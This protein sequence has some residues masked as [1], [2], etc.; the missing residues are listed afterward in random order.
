M[1][2]RPASQPKALAELLPRV[3]DESGLSE[4]SLGMRLVQVWDEVVGA[5]LAPHCR[6][7]GIRRGTLQATVRDSSWMQRLQME[8]PRVLAALTEALGEEAPADLRLRIG[9][10]EPHS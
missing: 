8:K 9:E 10:L 3:L 6:P 5:E 2:K 7:E 4:A 1:A